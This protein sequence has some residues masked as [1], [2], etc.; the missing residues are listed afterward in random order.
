MH[1]AMSWLDTVVDVSPQV[2]GSWFTA[3]KS[4]GAAIISN[5]EVSS[6]DSP[7]IQ[8][9][10]QCLSLRHC[11]DARWQVFIMDFL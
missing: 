8:G 10:H 7:Y 11:Y 2:P 5:A 1:G 9:D 4:C 3:Q 6:E